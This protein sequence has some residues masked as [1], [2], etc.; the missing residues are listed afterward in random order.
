MT[1][2]FGREM[3]E[4]A[5]VPRLAPIAALRCISGHRFTRRALPANRARPA[6]HHGRRRPT[7]QRQRAG[8][9][10]DHRRAQRQF[11]PLIG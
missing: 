10:G 11:T 6:D 8:G 4:G 2:V 3:Q 7:S 9:A 1:F 5:T